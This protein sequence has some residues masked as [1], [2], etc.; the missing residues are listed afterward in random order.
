MN[1]QSHYDLSKRGPVRPRGPG[2]DRSYKSSFN[3]GNSNPKTLRLAWETLV[4]W[5][6]D[7]YSKGRYQ[8]NST[9]DNFAAVSYDF[10][11]PFSGNLRFSVIF[12]RSHRIPKPRIKIGPELKS[13]SLRVCLFV[14]LCVALICVRRYLADL[15]LQKISFWRSSAAPHHTERMARSVEIIG[16][17]IVES[18]FLQR[19]AFITLFWLAVIFGEGHSLHSTRVFLG[20]LTWRSSLK[21]T[22]RTPT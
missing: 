1:K 17:L 11:D 3:K 2:Q 10:G 15:W 22:Q 8:V 19:C 14:S 20:V 12:S 7:K 13:K 5:L 6:L 16:S 18:L 4:G 9:C 21:V